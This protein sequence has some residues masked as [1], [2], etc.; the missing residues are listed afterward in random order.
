MNYLIIIWSLLSQCKLSLLMRPE[1]RSCLLGTFFLQ[2]NSYSSIVSCMKFL[3]CMSYNI[4]ITMV[5][6]VL[7]LFIII[8]PLTRKPRSDDK[9]NVLLCLFSFNKNLFRFCC[10]RKLVPHIKSFLIFFSIKSFFICSIC[11]VRNSYRPKEI[12]RVKP[13][14]SIKGWH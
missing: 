5:F 1:I 12:K 10:S 13:E 3:K 8:S 6:I 14:V 9:F 2:K 11:Q 7:F 4:A